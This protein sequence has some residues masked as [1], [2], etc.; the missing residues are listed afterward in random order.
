M[1]HDVFTWASLF[2]G[3]KTLP[4]HVS[5]AIIVSVILLVIVILGYKQL[6]R[7]EDEV[8]PEPRFTFGIL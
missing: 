6:K 7:T 1:G 4:P 5:N 3:L 8:V 2:P